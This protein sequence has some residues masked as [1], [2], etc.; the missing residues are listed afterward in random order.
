[1]TFALEAGIVLA[2]IMLALLWVTAWLLRHNVYEPDDRLK[3]VP[4]VDISDDV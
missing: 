1:M 3:L 2:W 4:T